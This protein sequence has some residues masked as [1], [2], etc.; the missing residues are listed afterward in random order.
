MVESSLRTLCLGLAA[1]GL[2]VAVNLDERAVPGG[3]EVNLDSHVWS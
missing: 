2:A 1:R 3:I